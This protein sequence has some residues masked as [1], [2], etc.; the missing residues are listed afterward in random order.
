MYSFL[1]NFE[2]LIWGGKMLKKFFLFWPNYC[3]HLAVWCQIFSEESFIGD[4]KY[5]YR[6]NIVINLFYEREFSHNSS[7]INSIDN[8]SKVWTVTV[9]QGYDACH[10]ERS[11]YSLCFFVQPLIL[12]VFKRTRVAISHLMMPIFHEFL[13]FNQF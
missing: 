13:I 6:L 9:H 3:S 5:V 7:N 12:I 2:G 8:V 10:I 4:F 1:G 11:K